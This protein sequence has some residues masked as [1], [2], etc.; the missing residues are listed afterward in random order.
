MNIPIPK[1][2]DPLSALPIFG[3]LYWLLHVRFKREVRQRQ[4]DIL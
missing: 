4:D 2:W 1:R 3:G